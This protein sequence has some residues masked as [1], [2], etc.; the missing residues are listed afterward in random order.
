MLNEGNFDNTKAKGMRNP[1]SNISSQD[2]ALKRLAEKVVSQLQANKQE[3]IKEWA[4]RL[5]KDLSKLS[6]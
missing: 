5:A 6:D 1:N 3:D 2:L 4:T